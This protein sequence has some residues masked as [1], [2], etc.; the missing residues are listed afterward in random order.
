MLI[1]KGFASREKVGCNGTGFA[2]VPKC[3]KGKAMSISEKLLFDRTMLPMMQSSLDAYS[4]R[5]KA[6]SNNIANLETEGYQRRVVQFEDLLAESIAEE[7][8]RLARSHPDHLPQAAELG[9]VEPE[10]TVDESMEYFNGVNN[11]DVDREMTELARA[12][13]SYRFAT[14]QIRHSVDQLRLAIRGTR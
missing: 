9:T 6:I 8:D 2:L 12:Q 7:G 1:F 4:L 14:R 13:L 10:L 5:Q 3:K 11:I